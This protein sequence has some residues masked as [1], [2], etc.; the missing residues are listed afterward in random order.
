MSIGKEQI[1]KKL[2]L[3]A[4]FNDDGFLLGVS[5]FLALLKQPDHYQSLHW[6]DAF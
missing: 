4:F 1:N 2:S 5:Y 6:S 3:K